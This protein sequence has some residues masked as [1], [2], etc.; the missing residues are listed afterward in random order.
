M[1]GITAHWMSEE[2]SMQSVVLA[3]K[4][5]DGGHTGQNIAA[6]VKNTLD[7]FDISNKLYCI[8]ADNT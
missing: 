5:I 3:L 2:F 6:L 7:Q 4:V 8:T 1:L